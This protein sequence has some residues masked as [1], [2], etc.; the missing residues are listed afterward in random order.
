[1][2]EKIHNVL[3]LC[4]GNSC[5]SILAE[6]ILNRIGDGHYRGYSAGSHPTGA[7][8]PYA[9]ELLQRFDHPTD[10]LRSKSWDEFAVVGAPNMDFIITVCDQAAG[11]V[12]PVWPGKPA[13]AHWSFPDPAKFEGP[14]KQKRAFFTKVYGNINNALSMFVSLRPETLDPAVRRHEL[15][16]IGKTIEQANR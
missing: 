5:R 15:A 16:A 3:F 12:C 6:S 8:N 4:T 2:A 13:V 14:D 9:I 11:E 7:V 1:M 10:H